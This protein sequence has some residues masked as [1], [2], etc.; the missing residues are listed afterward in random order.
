M[1]HCGGSGVRPYVLLLLPIL[2]NMDTGRACLK[3]LQKGEEVERRWPGQGAQGGGKRVPH[4][5]APVYVC[6]RRGLV[7]RGLG[8]C[9][10]PPVEG[11]L[12]RVRVLTQGSLRMSFVGFVG[13]AH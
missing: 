7:S 1:E 9:L 10:H 4:A 11:A 13:R 8:P 3:I 6:S 12:Q 2:S 5:L